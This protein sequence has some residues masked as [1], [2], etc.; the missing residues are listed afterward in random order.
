MEVA[1]SNPAPPIGLTSNLRQRFAETHGFRRVN[2]KDCLPFHLTSWLDAHPQW[3]SDWTKAAAV[4]IIHRPFNWAAKQRLIAL[5][6][7][8]AV[9]I[10]AVQADVG[11]QTEQTWVP[12]EKRAASRFPQSMPE[13]NRNLVDLGG[14]DEIVFGQAAGGVGPEGDGDAL[15]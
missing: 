3:E 13:L 15:R 9:P 6:V 11:S 1:G 2:D 5:F 10:R 8:I 7:P 14:Q 4:A 12:H